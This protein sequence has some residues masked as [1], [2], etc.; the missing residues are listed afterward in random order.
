MASDGRTAHR[1]LVAGRHRDH[2]APGGV[3]QRFLQLA[4]ALGRGLRES[5]AQVD[6]LEG[7]TQ[8]GFFRQ[9]ENPEGARDEAGPGVPLVAQ[10]LHPS[11]S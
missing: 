5:G 7:V 3:V 1:S 9:S 11:V 2:A 8:A 6:A 10:P 4:L